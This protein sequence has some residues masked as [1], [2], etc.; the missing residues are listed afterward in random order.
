MEEGTPVAATWRTI[1]SVRTSSVPLARRSTLAHPVPPRRDVLP[2]FGADDLKMVEIA[3][4]RG[5]FEDCL[6]LIQDLTFPVA[7]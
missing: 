5:V 4:D 2:L 3:G 7:P 1:S 6:C